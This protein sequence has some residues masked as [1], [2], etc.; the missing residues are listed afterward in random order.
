MKYAT[1]HIFDTTYLILNNKM[2]KYVFQYICMF[3]YMAILLQ[4]EMW[5]SNSLRAEHR[6]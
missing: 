1:L 6:F 3:V 4:I 5:L 2:H